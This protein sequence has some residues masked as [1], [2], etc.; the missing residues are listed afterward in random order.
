MEPKNCQTRLSPHVVDRSYFPLGNYPICCAVVLNHHLNCES[1]VKS[2]SP[3]L[4]IEI[5]K[6]KI[7]GFLEVGIFD[8]LNPCAVGIRVEFM[9]FYLP[10]P[11]FLY[12]LNCCHASHNVFYV[13][14]ILRKSVAVMGRGPQC[15]VVCLF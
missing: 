2:Q 10:I 15:T 13:S 11:P 6:P 9:H 7:L 3:P 4:T 14:T 5:S 12:I 8:Q 1:F